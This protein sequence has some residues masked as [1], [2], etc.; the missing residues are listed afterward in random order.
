MKKPYL[1]RYRKSQPKPM[2]TGILPGCTYDH[3]RDLI[4]HKATGLPAVREGTERPLITKKADVEKGEDH[5]DTW[6]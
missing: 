3:A 4:V 1:F 6:L 2:V 5:K